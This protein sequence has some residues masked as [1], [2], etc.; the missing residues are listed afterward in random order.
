MN[1]GRNFAVCSD[2]A[3]ASN[4]PICSILVLTTK[5]KKI[6]W[7]HRVIE[8]NTELVLM[9]NRENYTLTRA[10]LHSLLTNTNKYHLQKN[11]SSHHS[12]S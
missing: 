2:A 1:F 12:V 4:A 3:I 5:S 8:E 7:Q 11:H 10:N 9:K 6:N